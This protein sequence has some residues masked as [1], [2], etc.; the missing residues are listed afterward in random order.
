MNGAELLLKTAIK[1]G[2]EV[3]FSNPG[4]T[5]MPLV[6]AF[7]TYPDI[8]PILGF[9]DCV[10]EWEA[11]GTARLAPTPAMVHHSHLQGDLSS[12]DALHLATTCE[13]A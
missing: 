11:Y 7:D 6:N 8:R 5:E 1:A 13:K 10:C 9:L 3:C 2:V 12:V 4:T